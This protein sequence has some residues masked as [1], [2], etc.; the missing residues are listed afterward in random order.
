MARGQRQGQQELGHAEVI[1]AAWKKT[2]S[3]LG[4]AVFATSL[5]GVI[6]AWAV[7]GTVVPQASITENKVPAWAA[8]HPVLEPVAR[9]LGLHQAFTAPFFVAAVVLLGVSTAICAWRRTKV[10]ITRARVLRDAARSDSAS[11][12]RHHDIEVACDPSLTTAEALDISAETLQRLGAR[13]ARDADVVRDVSPWWTVAGSPVFHW[14]LLAMIVVILVG[15][16]LRAEGLMGLAVGQSKA[17][18]AASYGVVHTGPLHSWHSVSRI[19]RLDGFE[20]DYQTGGID[21]GPTPSVSVLD[22]KGSVLKAQR[23]YPNHTLKT[24]SLTIYPSDYGLAGWLTMQPAAGAKASAGVVLMDFSSETTEGTAPLDVINDTDSSNSTP[25][26]IYVSVPLD[27]TAAGPVNRLPAQPVARVIVTDTSS[28]IVY[29]AFVHPKE[30]VTLP[31]GST[32]RLDNIT[33]YAR[34]Q[35]V[36]DWSVALF[37]AGLVVALVGLAIATLTRQQVVLA[38]FVESGD[39]PTV[40]VSLR[41]WRNSSTSRSEIEAELGRA[42]SG[43]ERG[44]D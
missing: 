36:D 42:L 23:V 9:A 37:Y 32:L 34:L 41:L 15:N 3:F 4:S 7:L 26:R 25:Y 14:A 22:S 20:P 39:G 13:A 35:V 27:R 43:V 8:A 29:S 18:A 12:K 30:Q 38:T 1:K 31:S 28:H 16:L 21:R 24:G 19:I 2:V 11:I 33:Y 5:L 17:D 6:A 10:A 44:S 40:V